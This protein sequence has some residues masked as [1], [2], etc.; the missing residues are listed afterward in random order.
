MEIS[1]THIKTMKYILTKHETMKRIEQVE[2]EVEIPKR[3]K[4]KTQYA[5]D[6]IVENGYKNSKVVDILD[7]ELLDEEVVN[8]RKAR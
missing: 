3:I 5:D 8:L 4:N 7:S 1:A 2:Y 6:Q